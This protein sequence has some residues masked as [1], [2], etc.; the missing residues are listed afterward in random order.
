M[1]VT[2]NQTL[3][4][5]DGT[6][7]KEGD[8]ELNLKD[9]LSRIAL[10]DLDKEEKAKLEDFNLFLKI[11]ESKDVLEL[12]NKEASRLQEKANKGYST[13]L[14]GQINMILEG[15]ENPLK[16]IKQNESK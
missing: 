13:L 11:K 8:K 3:L 12:D 10:A 16:I 14:Y 6:P 2:V 7:L 4:S 5:E 9:S 15:K 1:K